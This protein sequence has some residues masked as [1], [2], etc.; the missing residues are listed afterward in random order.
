MKGKKVLKSI[1]CHLGALPRG[2]VSLNGKIFNRHSNIQDS[3]IN[4]KLKDNKLELGNK[5]CC[6]FI[7]K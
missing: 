3:G 4:A 2:S 7:G 1:P 6:V 5:A